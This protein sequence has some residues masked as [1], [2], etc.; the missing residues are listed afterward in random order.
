[1]KLKEN[2]CCEENSENL[3]CAERS[4]R[5]LFKYS[6]K[7]KEPRKADPYKKPQSKKQI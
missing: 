2:I 4:D 3:T 1:M 5:E 6:K 7:R